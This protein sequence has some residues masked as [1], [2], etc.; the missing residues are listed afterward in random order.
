MSEETRARVFDPY[1]STKLL[2]RGLGLAA[3]QGIIHSHGG[4]VTATST[5]GGGSTFEV[6][7]PAAR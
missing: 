1:Y 3:V 4:V 7:L 5:P 2:G 6:L